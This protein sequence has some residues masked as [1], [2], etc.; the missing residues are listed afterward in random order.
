MKTAIFFL[1]LILG[2][3]GAYGFVLANP[4]EPIKVPYREE[5][6]M[7]DYPGVAEIT[8]MLENM[9]KVKGRLVK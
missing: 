8:A 2:Q 4:P 3:A 5:C 6:E 1:G 9:P 7:S